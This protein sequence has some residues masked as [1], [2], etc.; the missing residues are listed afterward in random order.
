MNIENQALAGLGQVATQEAESIV[1]LNQRMG[2][3]K[4]ESNP[5]PEF[6]QF[7]DTFLEWIN[8]NLTGPNDRVQGYLKQLTNQDG[9]RLYGTT[10]KQMDVLTQIM[11]RMKEQGLEDS[12]AYEQISE[13]LVSVAGA[14]MFFLEFLQEVF[15]PSEDEDDRENSDW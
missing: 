1:P 11:V 9:E 12:E 10:K 8:E 7:Y 4:A 15:R 5:D 14:N 13:A 2:L 6:D 3:T